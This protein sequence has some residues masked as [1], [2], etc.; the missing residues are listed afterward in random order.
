[1]IESHPAFCC[2]A[3]AV[4]VRLSVLRMLA[5]RDVRAFRFAQE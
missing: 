5:D 2:A 3:T 1:M 4:W